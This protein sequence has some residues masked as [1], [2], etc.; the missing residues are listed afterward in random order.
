MIGDKV[1]AETYDAPTS[2]KEVWLGRNGM[3]GGMC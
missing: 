3:K 1:S 2:V